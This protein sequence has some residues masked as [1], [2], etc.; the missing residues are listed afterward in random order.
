M[1]D[2]DTQLHEKVR[3]MYND[4]NESIT[5]L[6]ALGSIS[7]GLDKILPLAVVT[8]TIARVLDPYKVD[9]KTNTCTPTDDDEIKFT[10]ASIR[11]FNIFIDEIEDRL[12]KT[13][14]NL[15]LYET[16]L[17]EKQKGELINPQ[18]NQNI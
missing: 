17:K 5:N 16:R 1:A 6:E 10:N 9:P 7:M 15:E 4:K 3:E 11:L 12:E 13:K 14:K 18:N 2:Q 8:E